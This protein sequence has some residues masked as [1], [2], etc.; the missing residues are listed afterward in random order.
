MTHCAGRPLA[1]N[2]DMK[3]RVLTGLIVALGLTACDAQVNIPP[4][5]VVATN[6]AP[7]PTASPQP[8]PPPAA[9]VPDIFV[10]LKY[11]RRTLITPATTGRYYNGAGIFPLDESAPSDCVRSKVFPGKRLQDLV[12]DYAAC[13][14]SNEAGGAYIID[15]RVADCRLE[16]SL[17]YTDVRNPGPAP[18]AHV[19]YQCPLVQNA[20]IFACEWDEKP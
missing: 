1:D 15:C 11:T 9:P 14:W 16:L 10:T 4:G 18:Y 5:A 13:A 6:T 17:G 20:Q 7:V 19:Y 3:Y 12:E 2:R 8:T